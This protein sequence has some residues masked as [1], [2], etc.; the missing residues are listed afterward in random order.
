MTLLKT[1]MLNFIAMAVKIFT[2][3]I[4]NKI[5]AVYVGPSGYALAS[6]FQNGI[7]F[8]TTFASG[9]INTGVTKYTAEY[10][11]DRGSLQSLWRTAV[12]ISFV[13]SFVLSILIFAL[14]NWISIHYL[15]DEA[16]SGIIRWF[17]IT[18]FMFVANIILLS[19]VNGKK[20]MERYVFIN[21]SGSIVSLVF[22]G[23][24]A[25]KFGLYGAFVSFA[26][27]QSVVFFVTLFLLR[28]M[29]WLNWNM[30]VGKPSDSIFFSKLLKFSLMAIVSAFCVVFLQ[31][32]IRNY[33]ATEFGWRSAGYWDGVW[34]ISSLYLMVVTVPLSVYYLPKLSEINDKKLLVKE[35]LSGYKL[36]LPVVV[37][38]AFFIYMFR[39]F[40]ISILFTS[41]FHSMSSL[42]GW[43]LLGDIM[44]L[45][46]W[47]LSYIMLSKA[48]TRTYIIT[49]ILSSSFFYAS[50]HYLCNLNG[51]IGVT[52]AYFLTY[53]CY[54]I[55]MIIVITRYLKRN[56]IL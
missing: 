53:F 40:I 18:I 10:S 8:V 13:S 7:N 39:T 20:L 27:N 24:M 28:D 41:E 4:L 3:L 14:S 46:S 23:F 19:I 12:I 22:S 37:A 16:Y 51:L 35:I 43:Q 17:S 56:I 42:M 48:L 47:L 55:L 32:L 1:G 26:T 6:Q 54:W 15:K 29:P 52:Q 5:M 34:R 44:K 25:W 36:V 49:E 21:I 31:M 45:G 38:S 9:A 30:F 11:A 2:G 33:I 50:V